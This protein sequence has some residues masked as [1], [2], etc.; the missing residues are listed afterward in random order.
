MFAEPVIV[1][2]EKGFVNIVGVEE[3]GPHLIR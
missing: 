1:D 3:D 2:G